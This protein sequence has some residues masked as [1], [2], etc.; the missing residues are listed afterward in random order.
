MNT[1]ELIGMTQTKW[2]KMTASQKEAIRDLS[3]LSWQLKGLEGYRVEV[4]TTYGEKR[5][6]IV[7]KSTGWKPCHLE[8]KTRRSMGGGCAEKTYKSVYIIEKVR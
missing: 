4:V 5:R 3:G 2:E 7:E 8:V 1:Q 6:F